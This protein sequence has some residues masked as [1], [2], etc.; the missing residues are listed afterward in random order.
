MP[1]CRD[2]ATRPP[3]LHNRRYMGLGSRTRTGDVI[4]TGP[5]A[6]EYPADSDRTP[7]SYSAGVCCGGRDRLQGGRG[8]LPPRAAPAD[9]HVAF[10]NSVREG[11]G[12][13]DRTL[14]PP[15]STTPPPHALPPHTTP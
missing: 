12:G 6:Y 14:L 13:D 5:P 1:P 11:G 2:L 15:P 3:L 7:E 8:R 9:T 4:A 10:P